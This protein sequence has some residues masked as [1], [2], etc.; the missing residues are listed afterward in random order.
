MLKIIIPDSLLIL[1]SWDVKNF[2][3]ALGKIL[4]ICLH[5]FRTVEYTIYKNV[6][7]I[8]ITNINYFYIPN[9][10]IFIFILE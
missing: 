5:C 2:F 9:L 1:N 4:H 8:S 10:N 3:K 7:I 6:V